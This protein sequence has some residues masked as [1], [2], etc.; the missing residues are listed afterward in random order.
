MPL[1]LSQACCFY[2]LKLVARARLVREIKFLVIIDYCYTQY[3]TW[4]AKTSSM[5]AKEDFRHW[6]MEDFREMALV[7]YNMCINF[8]DVLSKYLTIQYL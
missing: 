4:K 8:V 2:L 7:H 1:L 6:R 5:K 3:D